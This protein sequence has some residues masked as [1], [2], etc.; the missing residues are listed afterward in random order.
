MLVCAIV[1][2]IAGSLGILAFLCSAGRWVVAQF[3]KRHGDADAMPPTIAVVNWITIVLE[4][5]VV[6][7]VVIEKVVPP[8]GPDLPDWRK[9]V[10]PQPE[11]RPE[12]PAEVRPNRWRHPSRSEPIGESR[13]APPKHT[14]GAAD[15][16]AKTGEPG[17]GSSGFGGSEGGRPGGGGR[18]GSRPGGGFGPGGKRG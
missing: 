14:H 5:T 13:R 17:R 9:P 7:P 4:R 8:R 18:G 16:G 1:G 12:P 11:F 2:L 15:W 10:L 3:R 6:V